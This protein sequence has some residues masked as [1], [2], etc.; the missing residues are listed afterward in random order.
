MEFTAGLL[1]LETAL[2]EMLSRVSPL[3]AAQTL[4]LVACFGRR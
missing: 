4:P 2:S 1:P 3:T